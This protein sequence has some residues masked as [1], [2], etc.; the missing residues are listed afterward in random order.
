MLWVPLLLVALVVADFV[1]PIKPSQLAIRLAPEPLWRVGGWTIANTLLSGVLVSLFLLILAILATRRMVDTPEPFSLQNIFE[2]IIETIY[3]FIENTLGSQTSRFLPL[4]ATFFLFILLSNLCVFIP[5]VG[6]IG[7]WEEEGGKR[8]FAPLFRGAT[9]DLNT[10][11]ALAIIAV[12]SVQAAGIRA[13]GWWGYLSRFIAINR[14]IAFFRA[15]AHGQNPP[16]SQLAWGVMDLFVGLLELMGELTRLLSF[17]FRLFGNVFGGE[18][19][20]MVIAFL[21]P[22]ML[23][24]PFMFLELLGSFIQAYIF[25]VLT[26]TFLARATIRHDEAH[27]PEQPAPAG[28]AA[29]ASF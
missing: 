2:T 1:S 21:V 5:G 27:A 10:T 25:A 24:L 4:L 6:S 13:L 28:A 17:S 19:L 22:Y 14:F 15:T 20:L 9:G 8:L 29:T 18:V 7:F 23:S 16:V 11:V 26:L 3:G 12:V